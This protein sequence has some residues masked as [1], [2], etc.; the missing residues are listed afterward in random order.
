MAVYLR[1]GRPFK[2]QLSIMFL[3]A[4]ISAGSCQRGG[5]AIFQRNN[6][7]VVVVASFD[8][9]GRMYGQASGFIISTDGKVVTNY[10][11][12]SLASAIKVKQGNAFHNVVGLTHV[13]SDN[14]IAILKLEKGKYPAVRIADPD[15]VKVGETVY[16]IGSPEGLENT[17]S[18]GIVSGIRK[19]NQGMSIIQMTAP[20]SKGSSGGPI[21]NSRGEVVGISTFLVADTQNINFALPVSLAAKG[22]TKNNL[23]KPKEA[24]RVDYNKTAACYFY[25]GLAYG[26]TGQL[27]RAADSFKSSIAVDPQRIESYINLGVSYANMRKYTDAAD[28]F[29]KAL[30]LD[31]NNA[32]AL[33]KLGAVYIELEKHDESEEALKKSLAVNPDNTDAR[34]Y[35]A[36][37]YGSQGRYEEAVAACKEIIRREP[38]YTEAYA[39]LG[40]LLTKMKDY[41]EAIRIY[42]KGISQKPDDAQMHLGLGRVYVL[43]GDRASALDEYKVLKEKHPE[44]AAKLFKDI[45]G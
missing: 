42:K 23:V 24:C 25:Q 32:D 33:S 2:I 37:D 8:D 16:A 30:S 35:L 45:Y 19:I 40:S 20:I 44:I 43:S 18:Q 28:M 6:D 4:L 7:A 3:L 39:L 12:I 31:P 27:E 29:K 1:M 38:Q 34:F 26:T 5:N 21:F 22:L 13:D 10:H 14:D 41:P 36:V 15:K 17:M 9:E 11:V